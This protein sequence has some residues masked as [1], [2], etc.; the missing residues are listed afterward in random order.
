MQLLVLLLTSLVAA[1]ADCA[2]PSPVHATTGPAKPRVSSSSSST[3]TNRTPAPSANTNAGTSSAALALGPTYKT[4]VTFYGAGDTFGSPNCNTDTAACAF[5]T[6]PGYSAAAS[7]NLFGV[8]PSAGTGPACG[9]CWRLTAQTDSSGH[10]LSNAGNA[11][12][13]MVNNLCPAQGNPLCAQN[14]LGGVN[15]YGGNV[16][17]DLCR[18]SGAADAFFGSS[19]VGLAVG[20]AQQVDCKLWSGSVV[21]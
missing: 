1:T 19:G 18:D 12:V 11:I 15:Q 14:G 8:G 5:Y 3:T 21:R 17:F 9:T 6:S 7:Q 16:N 10:A 2:G 4:T 20:T 13:V